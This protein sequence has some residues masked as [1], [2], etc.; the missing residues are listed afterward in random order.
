MAELYPSL[1]QCAIVATAFKL[2][3]FPALQVHH[4]ASAS[5]RAGGSELE[6]CRPFGLFQ[7][8]SLFSICLFYQEELKTYGSC[9]QAYPL[10]IPG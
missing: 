6:F 7:A 8:V 10:V 9:A 4:F 3:L 5:L 2:L 1:A